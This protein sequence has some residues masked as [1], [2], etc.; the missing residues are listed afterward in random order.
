MKCENKPLQKAD[1]LH[2]EESAFAT[3]RDM[4]LFK[5]GGSYHN[6]L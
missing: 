5:M 4:L 2:V 6:P 1:S 3:L